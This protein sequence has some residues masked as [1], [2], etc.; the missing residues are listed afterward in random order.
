MTLAVRALPGRQQLVDLRVDLS[1]ALQVIALAPVVEVLLDPATS[2][3]VGD[4][5]RSGDV[6]GSSSTSTTVSTRA[7]STWKALDWKAPIWKAPAN[8]D[9][10]SAMAPALPFTSHES[11][12]AGGP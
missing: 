1:K 7:K 10:K 11:R 5:G 8:C 9:E 4:L 3:Q 6:A 2:L 12:E